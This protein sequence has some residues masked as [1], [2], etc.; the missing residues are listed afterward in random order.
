MLWDTLRAV[1]LSILEFS[2]TSG[3]REKHHFVGLPSG[4]WTR[5]LG[6][7]GNVDGCALRHITG[8]VWRL[9]RI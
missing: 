2:A 3:L 9:V 4:K 8:R 6:A 1:Q 7:P 5:T